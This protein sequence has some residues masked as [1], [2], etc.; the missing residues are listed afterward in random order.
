MLKKPQITP[1]NVL[2]FINW[3]L[4]PK[5]GPFLSGIE[6]FFQNFPTDLSGGCR[7]EICLLKFAP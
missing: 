7:E 2:M 6:L 4:F 3:E 1:P 5:N